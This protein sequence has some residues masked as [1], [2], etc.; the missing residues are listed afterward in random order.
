MG[1]GTGGT[2]IGVGQAMR[3]VNPETVLVGVEPDE[4]CTFLCGEIGRHAI[5]GIADGFVPGIMA[6]NGAMVDE[7]VPVESEAALEA[8]HY[9]ARRHGM[10]VG[11]SSGANY[12][13]AQE[14]RRQRPSLE[15]VVTLF[16][17]EGE[18]YISEHFS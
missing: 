3:A 15:T 10:F 6:R 11:P 2:L 4:S 16:C 1:I 17:D 18:K 9:L 5:E 14:L 12:T 7:F 13:A 8:M